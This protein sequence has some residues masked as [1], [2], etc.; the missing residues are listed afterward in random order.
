MVHHQLAIRIIV[1]VSVT[2]ANT[3]VEVSYSDMDERIEKMA[4][5]GVSGNARPPDRVPWRGYDP[6]TLAIT[7]TKVLYQMG[8]IRSNRKLMSFIFKAK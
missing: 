6:S 1:K 8:P 5:K 3:H 7:S 4:E 2:Y